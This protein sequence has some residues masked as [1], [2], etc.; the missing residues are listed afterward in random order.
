M[1]KR[2]HATFELLWWVF[3][4]VLAALILA[5]IYVNLPSYP[6]YLPNFMYVVVAITLTRYMFF[7]E[8]SWLRDHLLLQGALSILLLPLIFWMVQHFNTFITYFDEQGP[9]V[10]VKM[11]PQDLAGLLNSY[12]KTEYRFFGTWAVIAA[13]IT[14]LRL[15]YNVWVRYRAGVR[16]L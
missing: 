15:L 7:L 4:L 12:L 8:I 6:F 3:T 1:A 10:L 16:S 9:D 13:I 2:D 14:P 11:L 5:P